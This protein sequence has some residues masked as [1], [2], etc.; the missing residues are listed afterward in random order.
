MKRMLFLSIVLIAGVFFLAPSAS[1]QDEG[2]D[3]PGRKR[4]EELRKIKLVEALDLS[5]DQSIKIFAREKNFRKHE[6]T[7][8]DKRRQIIA[9]LRGI[10]KSNGADGESMKDVTALKDLGIE[11]VNQRFDYIL[12]LKDILTMKQIAKY[13]AFEDTFMNEVRSML[14]N[15]GRGGGPPRDHE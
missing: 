3:G 5:E 10:G 15:F 8:I 12:S 2:P 11:M 4:L 1:A 7:L 9:H 13:V 6:R 14:K